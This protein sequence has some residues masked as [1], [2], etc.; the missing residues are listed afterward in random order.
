MSEFQKTEIIDK[1]PPR[2][3]EMV[4]F[5]DSID[6]IRKGRGELT[7]A[8]ISALGVGTPEHDAAEQDFLRDMIIA[9]GR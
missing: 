6:V 3:A 9:P 1:N 8:E 2:Y 5:E 4:A 7:R